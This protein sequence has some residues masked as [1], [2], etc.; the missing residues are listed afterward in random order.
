MVSQGVRGIMM[1]LSPAKTMDLTPMESLGGLSTTW[2]D[3]RPTLTGEIA[4][5]MKRRS[6]T[7]LAKLLAV[8]K[9]LASTSKTYWDDFSLDAADLE[10]KPSK[11]C[12]FAY[13][14]PAFQG[15]KA[16]ECSEATLTYLQNN[17]RIL[18]AVYGVLRPLDRIQPYRLEM[19]SKRVL[20]NNERLTDF[21]SEAI[22]SRIRNEL[23]QHA[24]PILLNLASD[25]YFSALDLQQL[26]SGARVVKAVF[27]EEGKV[28]SVHAKRARG[29]MARFLAEKQVTS[30]EEV[31]NFAEE[32]YSFVEERSDDT[33]FVF[34]RKRQTPLKRAVPAGRSQATA[35][36][37]K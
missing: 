5:A 24:E 28:V 16:S 29:L 4:R 26:P 15:L 21:W 9:T 23:E 10:S 2:P 37:R 13:A 6:E 22:S 11:P 35:K 3:C 7:E 36:K 17:L 1:L 12:I 33:T 8:S 34:D 19:G 18:D 14:G 30:C 32:G 31:K 25:E 27:Q 20:D